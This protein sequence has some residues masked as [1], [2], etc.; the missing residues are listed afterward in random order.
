MRVRG[1]FEGLEVLGKKTLVIAP[2]SRSKY[3]RCDER[4]I[5][6][7]MRVTHF[8]SRIFLQIQPVGLNKHRSG[9]V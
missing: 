6:N 2:L 1:R 4:I 5:R 8:L 3:A 9:L 7:I